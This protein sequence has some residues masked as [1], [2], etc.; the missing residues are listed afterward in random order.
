[1][2]RSLLGLGFGL[3]AASAFLALKILETLIVGPGR[4][5]WAKQ[6]VMVVDQKARYLGCGLQ[7]RSERQFRANMNL[8]ATTIIGRVAV[9][10]GFMNRGPLM[11]SECPKADRRLSTNRSANWA[12]APPHER[13]AVYG[14]RCPKADRPL[15]TN[16][17]ANAGGPHAP[18]WRRSLFEAVRSCRLGSA[19]RTRCGSPLEKGHPPADSGHFRRMTSANR[20]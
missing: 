13:K 17:T 6:R 9:T 8:N 7:R 10:A 12:P 20:P 15:S 4:V 2:L 11:P 5:P 16:L 14:N 1:M 18:R 3:E 19:A